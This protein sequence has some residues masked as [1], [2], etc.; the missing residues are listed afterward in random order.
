MTINL[1]YV[2]NI[3][4]I[5]Y[6][7]INQ[8]MALTFKFIFIGDSGAGKTSINQKFITGKFEE[9]TDTTIGVIFSCK[10]YYSEKYQTHIKINF[11]DTAGQE[12]FRSIAPMYYRGSSAIL[13]VFDISN[14]IT[15]QNIIDYW[16]EKVKHENCFQIYLIGNKK[17]LNRQVTQKEASELAIKNQFDYLEISAKYDDL[18]NLLTDIIDSVHGRVIESGITMA[19]LKFY[20]V[21]V[22]HSQISKKSVIKCC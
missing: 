18:E 4:K 17:D 9:A 14:R 22:D 21:N 15:Y 5:M 12:R 1:N 13:L 3:H 8:I 11:W 7:I 10:Q 2:V 20:G 19:Q 6:Y 16:I